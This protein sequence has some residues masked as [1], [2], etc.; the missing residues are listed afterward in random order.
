MDCAVEFVHVQ[1]VSVH[2]TYFL[3]IVYKN[4]ALFE[5]SRHNVFLQRCDL[6]DK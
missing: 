6:G 3:G 1:I 5:K 2:V 4:A